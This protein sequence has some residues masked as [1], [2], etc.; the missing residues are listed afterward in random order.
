[1]KRSNPMSRIL[2]AAAWLMI[3]GVLG[4]V[5]SQPARAQDGPK[6]EAID[7]QP[8]PGQQVQITMRLSGPAPQPLSFTIDNPARISFDLPGTTLALPSR[9]I[10]VHTSGVDS[11]LAAETKDRT[12]LVMNLDKLVPYDTRVDGNN[13]IVSLGGANNAGCQ[14]R[15]GRVRRA[16]Q[17]RR[18]RCRRARHPQHRLPPQSGWRRPHPGSPDGPAHS[19]QPASGWKPDRRRL[20]CRSA[21]EPRPPL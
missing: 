1:M 7:V 19:Y 12:R 20:R 11:I 17:C 6:L 16:Q 13:I 3:A 18:G 10:D 8:L 15:D 4:T 5:P 21:Q 14:H 2:A 9:R